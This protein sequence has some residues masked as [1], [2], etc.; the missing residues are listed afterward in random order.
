[1][2]G[3]GGGAWKVAYADFV[4]AMMAFFMVMWL[5]SQDQQ[6][7]DAIAQ[8]F[9]E[10]VGMRMNG[11]A[12]RPNTSGSMFKQE[13]QGQVPGGAK[14]QTGRGL[15]DLAQQENLESETMVI[16]EWLLQDAKTS[17]AWLTKARSHL[18]KARRSL[19]IR[20]EDS[21][22]QSTAAK[23]LAR[24]MKREITSETLNRS[25]G[26]SQDLLSAALSKVEWQVVAEELL[27]ECNKTR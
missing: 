2:A 23:D 21:L 26:M 18:D 10:P 14:S 27:L 15:G 12:H 16:A 1:M 7:K 22:I 24:T 11:N 25:K 6:V 3:K 4:T 13:F 17:E 19:P 9:V 5:T 20:A 8:Y